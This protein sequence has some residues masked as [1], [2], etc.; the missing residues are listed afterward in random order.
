MD[1][2]RSIAERR[3]ELDRRVRDELERLLADG[4]EQTE[5]LEAACVDVLQACADGLPLRHLRSCADVGGVGCVRLAARE[6]PLRSGPYPLHLRGFQQAGIDDYTCTGDALL[7]GAKGAVSTRDGKLLT[8]E[9]HGRFSASDQFHIV[10]PAAEDF[11]YLRHVV[12]ALDAGRIA[13]G[14]D[15]ARVVE[16]A[17]LRSVF[18]P[19]P[20]SGA[21]RLFAEAMG[22]CTQAGAEELRELLTSAWMLATH[23]VARLERA[24]ALPARAL[25]NLPH[26]DRSGDVLAVAEG[27]LAALACVDEQP[28]DVVASTGDLADPASVRR[29][30]LCVCFPAPEQG[31]W[32]DRTVDADDPRW[33]FGPPPRNKANFAWVQQTVA[34]MEEGG[35]A[36]MLLCN[37][38]L[39]ADSGREAV[40]R[41]AWARSGLVEAVVSLPGGLFADGRPPV[42]LVVMRK[43]RARQGILFVNALEL[44]RD[45]GP[46]PSGWT[47]RS[48]EAATVSRIVDACASWER[49]TGYRDMPGFCRVVPPEEIEEREGVLTPWTYLA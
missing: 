4:D 13:K 14:T 21:R 47:A 49:G 7:V 31:V 39:H 24:E 6:L 45:L 43:G 12:G 26:E 28:I 46:N 34:C 36:L 1:T 19:W 37:A 40:V 8:V 2:A 29:A 33:V 48:L 30:A 3:S 20:H 18:V 17:D 42:S 27:M 44:G 41:R 23:D 5:F 22:L 15:A 9:A 16:L 38:A 32:T 11:A 10:R 35:R 25:P